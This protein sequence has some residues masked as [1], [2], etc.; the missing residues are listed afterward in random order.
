MNIQ[1]VLQ[2]FAMSVCIW[3]PM[4][5]H[6][7]GYDEC[8]HRDNYYDEGD[9]VNMSCEREK[10]LFFRNCDLYSNH[11]I[12]QETVVGKMNFTSDWRKGI[13]GRG[14]FD[15]NVFGWYECFPENDCPRRHYLLGRR[16]LTSTYERRGGAD[17]FICHTIFPDLVKLQLYVNGVNVTDYE[18]IN[19]T[20]R[21]TTHLIRNATC[22]AQIGCINR[23]IPGP[24]FKLHDKGFTVTKDGDLDCLRDGKGMTSLRPV[25]SDVGGRFSDEDSAMAVRNDSIRS[26]SCGWCITVLDNV[27]SIS[28]VFALTNV[29]GHCAITET[30]DEVTGT[31]ISGAGTSHVNVV[32]GID[33]LT[34]FFV[35]IIII[36]K[37]FVL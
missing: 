11:I 36:C 19:G 23:S 24:T 32:R 35:N 14:T 28:D 16:T 18:Y 12:L 13:I 10:F 31:F 6:I 25:N 22:V 1:R 33:Y 37:M 9:I 21:Y 8:F 7:C 2:S 4:L 20:I 27:I 26:T 29:S 30:L 15:H 34:T 5:R 17:T 3:Q